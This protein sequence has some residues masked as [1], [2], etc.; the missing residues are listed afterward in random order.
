MGLP[1]QPGT[2][3]STNNYTMGKNAQD[4]YYN[5][6]AR[7]DHNI[8][9]NQRFYGRVDVTTLER[10]ENIRQNKTV[11]DNFYRFNHGARSGSRVYRFSVVHRGWAL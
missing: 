8:S 5:D 1:N 10:P 11:G 2:I 6:L 7:V 3:D 4:T 9:Q